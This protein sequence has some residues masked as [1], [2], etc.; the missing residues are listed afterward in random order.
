MTVI[1]PDSLPIELVES[2][3]HTLQLALRDPTGLATALMASLPG[4]WPPDHYEAQVVTRALSMLRQRETGSPFVLHFVIA[5]P[6]RELPRIVAGM[7]G[8]SGPPDRNGIV[9]IGYGV[10]ASLA[11][12]GVASRAVGSLVD[13]ARS[14]GRVRGLAARTFRTM[15]ESVTVLERN[16]F[17][18]TGSGPGP[19]VVRYACRIE[20]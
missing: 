18:E 2:S 19:D 4:D 17:V 20:D 1:V 11:G 6:D 10:S 8:F 5:G 15:Q 7:A 12:R 13:M 14:S 9:E 3:E 16:G